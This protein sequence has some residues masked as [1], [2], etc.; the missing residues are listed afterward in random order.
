VGPEVVPISPQ[1][2]RGAAAAIARGFADNEVWVWVLGGEKGCRRILPRYYRVMIRRVFGPRGGAWTTSDARGGALWMPP[3]A[4][5]LSVGERIAEVLA[6]LP[7]GAPALGRG[8]RMA[9]LMADNRPRERHWYLNTLSVDPS[10]QRRGIGSALI[11]P[12]LARADA[13]GL[14]AYL[15]TQRRANIPFYRRF[16]FEEVAEIRLPDSPPLWTM[17]RPAARSPP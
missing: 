9:E 3:H 4:Q 13:E 11:G 6:L 17:W 10:A 2:N 1:L 14:G 15:E 7:R 8:G 12:G 5:R 16:G